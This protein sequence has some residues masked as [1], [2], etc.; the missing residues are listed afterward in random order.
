[1]KPK[2]L[3][4]RPKTE[5][6][7]KLIAKKKPFQIKNISKKCRDKDFKIKDNVQEKLEQKLGSHLTKLIQ[8][9]NTKLLKETQNLYEQKSKL[10]SRVLELEIKCEE[11]V[12]AREDLNNQIHRQNELKEFFANEVTNLRLSLAAKT[13]Q[14]EVYERENS[15]M[16]AIIDKLSNNLDQ[17]E[18]SSTVYDGEQGIF[19]SNEKVLNWNI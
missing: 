4:K 14:I 18:K 7:N 3:S 10:E 2:R 12:Q 8:H 16:R 9:E 17:I 5:A 19:F 13:D 1:M 11:S 15:E 6:S